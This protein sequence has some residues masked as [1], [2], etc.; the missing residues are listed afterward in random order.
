MEI[1]C[2]AIA[3]VGLFKGMFLYWA[4][5]AAYKVSDWALDAIA[6]Y[7]RMVNY[8]R[9]RGL[10]RTTN[11]HTLVYAGDQD[12]CTTEIVRAYYK[13]DGIVSCASLARWLAKFH[14]PVNPIVL[15]HRSNSTLCVS[16]VDLE[17]ESILNTGQDAPMGDISLESLPTVQIWP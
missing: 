16:V 13:Y 4:R 6:L 14:T 1:I 12:V 15:I 7:K 11:S 17:T 10:E 2:L 8:F 5:R 3:A 9:F